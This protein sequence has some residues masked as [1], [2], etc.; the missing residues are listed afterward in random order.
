MNIAQTQTIEQAIKH[1]QALPIQ[2]QQTIFDYIDLVMLDYQIKNQ[3]SDDKR[4]F[5][6]YQNKGSFK[7]SD[8]WQMSEEELF[9]IH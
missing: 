9:L 6:L 7:L 8:D 4:Q 5:G 2:K 3:E 1:I